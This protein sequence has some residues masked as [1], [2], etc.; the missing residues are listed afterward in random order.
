MLEHIFGSNAR[1]KILNIFFKN[2]MKSFYVRELTRLCAIQ[3]N[4]VRR[5]IENLA[6][7]G[8]LSKVE[9]GRKT[10]KEPKTG[11]NS[12][13]AQEPEKKTSYVDGLKK[14]YTLNQNFLLFYE[15]QALILKSKLY[16]E[17]S[18]LDKIQD[19]AK[20]H[21][22]ILAG[23]FSGVEN[24]P[25]DMLLVGSV[26]RKK[27]AK[28]INEFER[29]L[30]VKINYTVM[31]AQEYKYRKEITDKFLYDIFENKHTVVLDSLS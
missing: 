31:S 29:E 20:I 21:V 27:L 5:E 16:A 14:Y 12:E 22:L 6:S 17:K 25:T 19:I 11:G 9:G 10:A 7:I 30:D 8:L 28:I 13:S 3:L 15:L 24:A 26:D 4:S 1:V 23:F 2:P 18:M